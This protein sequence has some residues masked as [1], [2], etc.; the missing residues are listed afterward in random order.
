[1]SSSKEG[2][3]TASARVGMWGSG[4]RSPTDPAF[5]AFQRSFGFDRR[6][7]PYEIRAGR[8]WAE[9]LARA[10]LLRPAERDA[11]LRALDELEAEI[12]SHKLSLDDSP[13]EDVHDFVERQLVERIGETGYK[14][15]T[16][17]SRNELIANDLRLFVR[18]AAKEIGQ[19]LVEACDALLDLARKHPG[20][21]LP[22]FTHLRPAQP[23][24]LAHHLLAY[25]E[26]FF[27]D[28]KKLRQAAGEADVLVLGS[29]ALA[30]CTFPI[31]RA[32]LAER[33]GFGSISQNSLDAVSDRDF[34]LSYLFALGS[35]AIHL[36]RLAE[37]WILF[38]TEEFGFIRLPDSFTTGS[39]LMPQ[40]KNP[41]LWELARGK[42]GRILGSLV[43]LFTLFK[44]LP[45]GYQ[46]DLQE[47]KEGCFAAHD[48]VHDLLAVLAPALR[49][50]EFDTARMAALAGRE[51][52]LATD[53]ADYLVRRGVPF[54]M[55]HRIIA[56]LV[57][58]AQRAGRSVLATPL[59]ELKR[60]SPAFAADFYDAISL[61]RSLAARNVPGGTA[62]GQV[63]AAIERAAQELAH[64][65]E[66]TQRAG[67]A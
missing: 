13:A 19:G 67:G 47:D 29:G 20:A 11:I 10:G 24:L 59:E 9:A 42:T 46:K 60:F 57:A 4:F 25:V 63:R 28:L 31:D 52:L 3:G 65:R 26:M 7:L 22:G 23:L 38:S 21:A 58:E 56:D 41:D 36:S 51:S 50:T 15:H 64:W 61:D 6:L 5:F 48:A 43:G 30:G 49:A 55:A 16:G 33:L 45:L 32:F 66:A 35:I 54:R 27:R 8:A 34:L 17:R 44:G 1:M 62:P 2:T 40:K 14:L 12:R 53:M 37:D 18:D 39:S